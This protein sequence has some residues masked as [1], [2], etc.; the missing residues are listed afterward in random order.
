M[1][2]PTGAATEIA[3]WLL[4][5]GSL[6]WVAQMSL[7]HPPDSLNLTR[8]LVARS[9]WD[10][11]ALVRLLGTILLLHFLAFFSGL[12]LQGPMPAARLLITYLIYVVVFVQIILQYRHTAPSAS[13]YGMERH[14]LI[15]FRW[16]PIAYLSML[17]FIMR[18]TQ[19]YH[20]LLEHIF[21]VD[22]E[23]QEIV[24]HMTGR[25][26]LLDKFYIATAVT[27]APLY[28]EVLFRGILFPKLVE[29]LGLGKGIAACSIIFALLHNHLPS[30]VPLAVLAAVLCLL[31]WRTGSLW[32][33]IGL[34]MLFNAVSIFVLRLAHH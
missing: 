21:G 33:C 23:M 1:D 25:L 29:K 6:V 34:H 15:Q 32:S 28:E 5:L 3:M 24:E 22:I 17:P 19:G 18:F 2:A 4:S 31:Y 30:L 13:P 12:F 9:S 11:P 8:R 7:R 14:Q 16:A 10:R 27:V 20:F 26:T